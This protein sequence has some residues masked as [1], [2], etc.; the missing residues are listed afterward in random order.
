MRAWTKPWFSFALLALATAAIVFSIYSYRHRFVRS[1]SDMVALLPN[2]GGTLFFANLAALRHAGLLKVLAGSKE[3]DAEYQDF[4]RQTQFDYTK[5]LDAFAGEADG[6][7]VLLILRGRFD[8]RKLRQY[9]VTHGGSCGNVI[10][11]VPTSRV[12]RWASFSS[13]QPDV[14]ALALSSDTSA[15]RALRPNGRRAPAHLPGEPVWVNVSMSYLKNPTA[16]PQ[17]VRIFA[18]SLQSADSVVLSLSRAAENSGAAFNIELDAGC[19]NKATAETTRNQL[20][21]ETKMLKL[22]L[23]HERQQPNPADLTGL[24]TAGT[25]H[26]INEHVIGRWPVRKELL[27]TIE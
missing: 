18:I 8:W 25:F 2:K 5:N 3:T 27:K 26:V 17:E 19:R 12:G 21:I 24:L 7:Q 23:A 6:D 1:E 15:I 11:K 20:E 14:M 10:C 9:A 22:E 4:V 16:L 13:I